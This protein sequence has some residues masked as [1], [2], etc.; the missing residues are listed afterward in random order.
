MLYDVGG[1]WSQ[2]QVPSSKL[3]DSVHPVHYPTI[4]FFSLYPRFS[5]PKSSL[6]TGEWSDFNGGYF[7]LLRLVR[8]GGGWG[9][10]VE[11]TNEM[12]S[13]LQDPGFL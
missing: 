8:G 4:S 11:S 5:N 3:L 10:G 12:T 2:V 9:V 1:I 6:K 7:R 13:V